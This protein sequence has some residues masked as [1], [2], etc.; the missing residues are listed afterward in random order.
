M[1]SHFATS[2]LLLFSLI[3]DL[4]GEDFTMAKNQY[5][6][7]MLK[8]IDGTPAEASEALVVLAELNSPLYEHARKKVMVRKEDGLQ[9]G[10]IKA[11]MTTKDASPEAIHFLESCIRSNS[12]ALVFH[13]TPA[14]R[15][16]PKIR[17]RFANIWDRNRQSFFWHVYSWRYGTFEDKIDGI[18]L[19][20]PWRDPSWKTLDED[21]RLTLLSRAGTEEAI[22]YLLN[23]LDAE[24]QQDY[25][26]TLAE[27]VDLPLLKSLLND[28]RPAIKKYA[29]LSLRKAGDASCNGLIEELI[30]SER[31]DELARFQLPWWE[32]LSELNSKSLLKFIHSGHS[33]VEKNLFS[34]YSELLKRDEAIPADQLITT[35]PALEERFTLNLRIDQALSSKNYNVIQSILEQI[36]SQTDVETYQLL[37]MLYVKLSNVSVNSQLPEE[38]SHQ[39]LLDLQEWV[40]A[41]DPRQ[42]ENRTAV[43]MSIRT[44][45]L[46]IGLISQGRDREALWNQWKTSGQPLDDL[47]SLLPVFGA[48]NKRSEKVRR[49]LSGTRLNTGHMMNYFR[50]YGAE[51]RIKNYC[52]PFEVASKLPITILSQTSPR[53][54]QAT[55]DFGKKLQNGHHN[56]LSEPTDLPEPSLSP[57]EEQWL[58]NK[59]AE[60][61]KKQFQERVD[62]ILNPQQNEYFPSHSTA[63]SVPI[64]GPLPNRNL[65]TT[66]E[67]HLEELRNLTRS[68]N[69]ILRDAAL[70]ALWYLT[71]DESLLSTWIKEIESMDPMLRASALNHLQTIRYDKARSFFADALFS[72]DAVVR[73]AGLFGV[74]ALRMHE[75]TPDVIKLLSD[76]DPAIAE[77]AIQTLGVVRSQ[78]AFSALVPL[79]ER[80]SSI[81]VEALSQYREAQYLRILIETWIK[82]DQTSPS[83]GG[84]LKTLSK[85][86]LLEQFMGEFT[87]ERYLADFILWWRKNR[88]S[89]VDA[90]AKYWINELVRMSLVK[91]DASRAQMAANRLNN[92]F[93]GLLID[94]SERRKQNLMRFSLWWKFMKDESAWKLL[95]SGFTNFGSNRDLLMAIDPLKTLRNFFYEMNHCKITKG[96]GVTIHNLLVRYASKDYGNPCYAS[97]DRKLSITAN[98]YD[99]IFTVSN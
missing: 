91:G 98:W 63:A 69:R 64:L 34:I 71:G 96:D 29:C 74:Q 20:R 44:A 25:G 78:E 72:T 38:I 26:L 61:S 36:L 33:D 15:D 28:N 17:V 41:K 35:Y 45:L 58:N 85:L 99:H 52:P 54:I 77:T 19:A 1:R 82:I 88:K 67:I 79:L 89:D 73:Q 18:G 66:D 3:A 9:V 30:E 90:W 21:T 39:L 80:N 13:A 55:A 14:I 92:L 23:A 46:I 87:P 6:A 49:I 59:L 86:T 4:A 22:D 10:I 65:L 53:V 56:K 43:E 62:L 76:P 57:E 16:V 47:N 32:L 84:L 48:R 2:I 70:L 42:S 60:D 7:E 27:P 40:A 8:L 94:D 5:E 75:H 93:G 50:D 68:D 31:F 95:K 24:K 37:G 12:D 97:C 83:Y 11:I 81:L 51:N